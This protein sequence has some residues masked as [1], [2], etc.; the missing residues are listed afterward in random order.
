[1]CDAHSLSA[2]APWLPPS[3]SSS[4][5][6]APNPNFLLDSAAGS[7]FIS[8]LTGYPEYLTWPPFRLGIL[9]PWGTY[10]LSANLPSRRVAF[11][12]RR[13]ASCR[14]SGTPSVMA[15]IEK[16][17]ELKPPKLITAAYPPAEMTFL[18]NVTDFVSS[19]KNLKS[20]AGR[21]E[22][23]TPGAFIMCRP[24]YLPARRESTAFWLM[25]KLASSPASMSACPTASPGARCP[26][27]PPQR[28][29]NLL[30]VPLF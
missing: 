22:N 18:P 19:V 25:T 9:T 30:I 6:S 21:S 1:M 14:I 5:P 28:M 12:A 29:I 11:P 10:I 13:F 27:V 24:E 26:P 20:R 3:T 17:R 4:F 23:A 2:S 8:L 16:P 15:A 7:F